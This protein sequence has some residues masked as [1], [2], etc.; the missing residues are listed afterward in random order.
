VDSALEI[1]RFVK[2]NNLLTSDNINLL[3][4]SEINL[5]HSFDDTAVAIQGYNIC[6]RDRHACGGGVAVYIQS[7]IPVMLRED[8]LSSVIEVLWLQ[9][10]T[11]NAFS[12]RVLL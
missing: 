6:R 3:T 11:S 5:D 8:L 10:R 9:V 7:H 2:I 4:I 1:I 12:F